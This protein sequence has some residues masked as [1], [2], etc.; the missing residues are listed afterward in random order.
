MVQVWDDRSPVTPR[1][2]KQSFR[3]HA[4]QL[5]CSASVTLE[6]LDAH[7]AEI[8]VRAHNEFLNAPL[9]A[10]ERQLTLNKK[11]EV[12]SAATDREVTVDQI[13]CANDNF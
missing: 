2:R 9:D 13:T 12:L 3:P 10:F 4:Q 8:S 1:L 11:P 7:V 5:D 6:L